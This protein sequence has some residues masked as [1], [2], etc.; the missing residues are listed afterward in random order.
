MSLSAVGLEVGCN[1]GSEACADE[2]AVYLE[3]R[4]LAVENP[5]RGLGYARAAR[6]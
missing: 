4:N 3:T 6:G 1:K 5:Q 2:D